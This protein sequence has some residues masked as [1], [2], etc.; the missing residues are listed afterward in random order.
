MI[1]PIARAFDKLPRQPVGERGGISQMAWNARNRILLEMETK[2]YVGNLPY[3]TT[4][5]DLRK[6]FSQAGT[7]TSAD[8]IKDRETGRSKGFGFVQMSNESEAEKAI[9][10][11]NGYSFNDRELKVNQARPRE[12]SGRGGFRRD[13]SYGRGGGGGSRGR[14]RNRDQGSSRY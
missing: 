10:M 9:S 13:D 4:E 8:V 5:E 7:V 14:S 2:L 1:R 12:E 6:L 11:F 3:T